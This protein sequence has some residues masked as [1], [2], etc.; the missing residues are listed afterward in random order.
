MNKRIFCLLLAC[1][2]ILPLSGCIQEKTPAD[3]QES[4]AAASDT[5]TSDMGAP[6]TE[7][8]SDTE[9]PAPETTIELVKDGVPQFYIIVNGT[10]FEKAAQSLAN[11]LRTKTGVDFTVR[12]F[13]V[14]NEAPHILYVGGNH[15][16]Y[17]SPPEP[18]M[19][20]TSGV[21]YMDGN[22]FV[23]GDT[24]ASV[25]QAV[26]RFLASITKDM[27]I[28]SGG[29]TSLAIPESLLFLKLSDYEVKD[30][31]LLGEPLWK[32]RI[33]RSQ[34]A[35]DLEKYLARNLKESIAAATGYELAV[36]TDTEAVQ[37]YEILLG[38]ARGN[39]PFYDG[40]Y[41][42]LDYSLKGVGTSL[43]V[44]FGSPQALTEAVQT[45][46]TLYGKNAPKTVD[47]AK[48][49][50]DTWQVE[51]AAGTDVRVMT[52]NTLVIAWDSKTG[53][54]DG[55]DRMRLLADI[56]NL[57]MP[58]FIGLQEH[59]APSRELITPHLDDAYAYV[60]IPNISSG[61]EMFPILYRTD[62]WRVEECGS[63]LEYGDIHH[64]W[65]FVWARFS[66]LSDPTEQ[67]LLCNLHYGFQP[68][69]PGFGYEVADELNRKIK[70]LRTS[71]PDIPV[72]I[73]GDHNS[74]RAGGVFTTMF[75]GLP[76]EVSH[77]LTDDTNMKP[78]DHC[79]DHISVTT[80]KIEVLRHRW[81]NYFSTEYSSDHEPYYADLKFQ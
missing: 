56:Y 13:K 23:C 7:S 74:T 18:T 3:G 59:N 20:D 19:Y 11:G 22:L 58:D 21:C 52:S 38:D 80:D 67:V 50:A 8:P 46:H 44:G 76:L 10:E 33:V 54:V 29:K 35:T 26:T 61:E 63:G 25:T 81:L 27:V 69:Y 47:I 36:V 1:L 75:D 40:E 6:D 62:L 12:K 17:L 64:P 4:G 55:T 14:E 45:F 53:S 70:S 34:T 43:Y 51:R 5:A 15:N 39:N 78:T 71:Y 9:A 31:K 16:K 49:A 30:P 48:A 65:G 60:N 66:R 32:Y 2:M 77:L 37:P 79:I 72:V 68:Q 24:V 41:G 57:Y 28:G 73:T 42:L